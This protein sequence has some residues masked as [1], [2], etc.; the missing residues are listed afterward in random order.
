MINDVMS[1]KEAAELWNL[2]PITVKHLCTGVQGRP[3]RLTESE[4][5]KSGGVWLITREGMERLYG[6][7]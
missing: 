1:V 5:N 6:K 2:S 7:K 3:P 4:C